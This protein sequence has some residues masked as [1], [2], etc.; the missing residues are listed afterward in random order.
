MGVAMEGTGM[1]FLANQKS[2]QGNILF[3]L[4]NLFKIT[5]NLWTAC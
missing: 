1:T 2:E 5:G 4:L 3:H